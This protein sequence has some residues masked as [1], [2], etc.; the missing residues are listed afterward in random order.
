MAQSPTSASPLKSSVATFRKNGEV[1]AISHAHKATGYKAQPSASK[2][3][4]TTTYKTSFGQPSG[5]AAARTQLPALEVKKPKAA[6][7]NPITGGTRDVTGRF[8][9][10]NQKVFV[11]HKG[12]PTGY[13][14]QGIV[15]EQSKWIHKRQQD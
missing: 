5:T 3:D 9:T 1:F 12:T 6:S 7:E 4:G 10:T 2:F 14:N 8:K 11:H 15:A 13:C